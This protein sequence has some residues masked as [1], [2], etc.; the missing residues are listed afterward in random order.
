MLQSTLSF[1]IEVRCLFSYLLE[2]TP[3]SDGKGS[4]TS[5]GALLFCVL[6]AKRLSPAQQGVVPVLTRISLVVWLTRHKKSTISVPQH[7]LLILP[8]FIGGGVALHEGLL[9]ARMRLSTQSLSSRTPKNWVNSSI[10]RE[11]RCGVL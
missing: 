2:V 8:F 4:R 7:L 9:G 1:R 11:C 5:L 6:L 3:S 10:L